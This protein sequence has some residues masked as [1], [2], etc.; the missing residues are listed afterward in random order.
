MQIKYLSFIALLG[1][2]LCL[3]CNTAPLREVPSQPATTQTDESLYTIEVDQSSEQGFVATLP[4]GEVFNDMA[5]FQDSMPDIVQWAQSNGMQVQFHFGDNIARQLDDVFQS[6]NLSED[7]S[8][9]QVTD[10]LAVSVGDYTLSASGGYHGF[11]ACIQT[12]ASY[13]AVRLNYGSNRAGN[14]R[15]IFDIHFV[16]YYQ[17]GRTCLA[18]YESVSGWS[19]CACEPPSLRRIRDGI[20]TVAISVGVGSMLASIFADAAAAVVLAAVG[21]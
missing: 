21:A 11:L 16:K 13:Y 1:T 12:D 7:S 14:F 8:L 17:G 20:Y 10:P 2:L 3:G 19:Q 15:Q 5:S 4:D 9:G 6:E 18:I